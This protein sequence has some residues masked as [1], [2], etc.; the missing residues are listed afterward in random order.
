MNDD[1][2]IPIEDDCPRV[3]SV[4]DD[5]S[6]FTPSGWSIASQ[7]A[8]LSIPQTPQMITFHC[9]FANEEIMRLDS[10]GMIYKGQRIEDGGEA[11]RAF[12]DVMG[13]MGQSIM[14]SNS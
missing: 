12:L 5:P 3:R 13:R 9:G 14:S 1:L 11:H 10:Q 4:D 6:S 7:N 2:F 8:S